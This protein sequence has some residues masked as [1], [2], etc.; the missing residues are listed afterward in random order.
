LNTNQIRLD[1][2]IFLK[3]IDLEILIT[4]I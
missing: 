4:P 3:I 2:F 1:F